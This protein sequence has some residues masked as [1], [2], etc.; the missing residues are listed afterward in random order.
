MNRQPGRQDPL[1][2]RRQNNVSGGVGESPVGEF[3][4]RLQSALATHGV[5]VGTRNRADMHTRFSE[6]TAPEGLLSRGRCVPSRA[7]GQFRLFPAQRAVS[8]QPIS[9]DRD[10]GDA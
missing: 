5:A 8:L 1:T 10:T 6:A 2:D 3:G 9:G 4:G 7:T